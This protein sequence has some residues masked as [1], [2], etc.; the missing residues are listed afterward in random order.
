MNEVIKIIDGD[1]I[2]LKNQTGLEFEIRLYGIDAPESK[3]CTKLKQD[4]R[5]THL[6]GEFL[7]F[8]GKKSTEYLR[9]IAPV[10]TKCE[11]IQEPENRI[12]V[13]GRT[14]AYMIL[15]SGEEVNKMMVE[16]G[17]AK[18]YDKIFCKS[19]PT[20]QTLNLLAMKNKSGLYNLTPTF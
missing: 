1:S 18:P 14:L 11:I 20:Y 4:E 9:S 12:D 19:L 17:F 10:G 13:Y 2:I 7:I 15:P 6:A 16:N 8:L 5:E 3:K